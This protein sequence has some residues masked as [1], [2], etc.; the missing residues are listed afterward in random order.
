MN[1]WTG[2]KVVREC[3]WNQ[4]YSIYAQFKTED[5]GE[6]SDIHVLKELYG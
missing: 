3:G 6:C 4:E 1:C 5:G 2:E